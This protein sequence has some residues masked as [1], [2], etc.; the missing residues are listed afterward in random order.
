MVGCVTQAGEQGASVARNAVLAAGWPLE[1][2]GVTLNRF[3]GSGLQAVNFAAMGVMSGQQDLVVGGGVESMSRV[4]MGS[5]NAGLDGHNL[6]LR[7]RHFQVPQGIGA[8]LIAT[9]EGF[10]RRG[11]RP[12]RARVAA[13]GGAGAGAGTLRAQ[14]L[15]GARPCLGRGRARSRRAPAPGDDSRRSGAA[16]AGLRRPR[17]TTARPQRRDRRTRSRS[18]A[19]RRRRGASTTCTPPATRAAS[20]TAPPR[21]WS[22][23]AGRWTRTACVP[24][25]RIRRHGDARHRAADHAHGAGADLPQGA[26]QGRAGAERHRA[27]GDQ[28]GVRRGASADHAQARPRPR[29][30]Q[31][32]R[33]RHRPGPPSGCHRG[34]AARHRCS[35]SWSGAT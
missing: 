28:R 5:D 34:D 17:C 30:G 12:L 2:T 3:C 15:C 8:D 23:R 11:G 14:P 10:S 19:I 32:Q 9:L 33:W 18:L 25:A 35:T 21:C 22:P 20:S 4:P 27:L 13:S 26:R 7:E 24:R 31:C 1:V 16:R 29:K 6:L